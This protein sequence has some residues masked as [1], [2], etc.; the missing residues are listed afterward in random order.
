MKAPSLFPGGMCESSRNVMLA[1]SPAEACRTHP[2]A[3]IWLRHIMYKLKGLGI[4]ECALQLS[5][6]MPQA[7]PQTTSVPRRLCAPACRSCTGA[8]KGDGDCMWPSKP[9]RAHQHFALICLRHQP[10]LLRRL[11]LVKQQ[12]LGQAFLRHAALSAVS[13]QM[14]ALVQTLK[15]SPQALTA[16]RRHMFPGIASFCA[17]K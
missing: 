13:A 7:S 8:G 10:L 15:L 14:S 4:N 3:E 17:W 11:Q 2:H 6:V 9:G 1:C 16:A 12:Q 5:S